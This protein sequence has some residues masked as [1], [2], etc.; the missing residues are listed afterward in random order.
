VGVPRRTKDSAP[1]RRGG[2]S[3]ASWIPSSPEECTATPSW[4]VS[5]TPAALTQGADA[6][7]K[8]VSSRMTST[9][10]FRTF[11]AS[12]SK[13]TTTVLV[14]SREPQLLA[15]VAHAGQADTGSSR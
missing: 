13:F 4:N 3:V 7:Q 14:A 2:A 15:R 1:R 8:V 6:A 11:A 5:Q 10:R 9:A 12:C